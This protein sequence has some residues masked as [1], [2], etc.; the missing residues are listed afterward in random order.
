V[1]R[2]SGPAGLHLAQNREA[3]TVRA[4][5]DSA[6][7]RTDFILA[8]ST[9]CLLRRW[10]ATATMAFGHGSRDYGDTLLDWTPVLT[11]GNG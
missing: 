4:K 2:T 3:K 1:T 10:P 6:N 9:E 11:H 7:R 5:E 8:A